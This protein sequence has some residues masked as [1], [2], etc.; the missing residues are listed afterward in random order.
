MLIAPRRLLHVLVLALPLAVAACQSQ[1]AAP[2]APPPVSED[3]WAVVDGRE[4]RREEVE[5]AYRR[6]VQPNQPISD[7][8]ALN[9]KLNL[10]D[11]VILEDIM[12]ARAR[13]LKIELPESE[14]DAAFNEGKKNIP[15]AAF[16][17]E[18]AARNLTPG[19]MREGLRRDLTARKVIE[20][21]VAS[22]VTVTDKDV[23]DFFQANKAQF[24]LPED[25]YH[26]AQIVITAAKEQQITNR[27]GDD[28]TTPQA[29]T[30]KAQMLMDRLKGGAPFNEVAMDYSEDPESAP[31][32]GDVGLVPVSALR[33]VPPQ[34]RDAV[35][36]AQPGTVSMVGMEGGYT[37]VALVA[38][39]T[40]GQRD[41]SM[42]DVRKGIEDTLRGRR[43]QLLRT[44]YVEAIRNRATV[45]N[46]LA[47]RIVDSQGKLPPTMAPAAPK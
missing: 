36:K 10:L 43:E 18:L 3:V 5:K 8:E 32:G 1:P 2:P 39:Q 4:I 37:I 42:P 20:Q 46:H 13:E 7:D 44:A 31:R 23:N 22:K 27:T 26:I 12:L 21:E 41:P 16:N 9:A 29:A 19:D 35:V 34:L 28:A 33:Q 6:T 47:R 25:A 30:T 11:Q 45:V 38:R 17:Q 14:I 15:D 40:A 24:N